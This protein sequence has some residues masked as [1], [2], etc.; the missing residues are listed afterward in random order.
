MDYLECVL[1]QYRLFFFYVYKRKNNKQ[2]FSSRGDRPTLYLASV[3]G[4]LESI[5]SRQKVKAGI[6]L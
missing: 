5:S 1:R 4:I 6:T 2:Y 3:A